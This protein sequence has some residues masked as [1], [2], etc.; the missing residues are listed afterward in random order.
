MACDLTPKTWNFR[1]PNRLLFLHE[2]FRKSVA[3]PTRANLQLGQKM[4]C[5]RHFWA[6]GTF[7]KSSF[8]SN[9]TFLNLRF[10]NPSE[11]LSKWTTHFLTSKSSQNRVQIAQ[12]RAGPSWQSIS[13]QTDLK[14]TSLRTP[15]NPYRIYS[16]KRRFRCL[17]PFS[18][19]LNVHIF[20]LIFNTAP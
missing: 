2:I 10:T 4:W 6:H 17:D 15:I 12:G 9:L 18:R 20:F 5:V 3:K 8:S 16:W 14:N 19:H 7:S 11:L 13:E 1:P